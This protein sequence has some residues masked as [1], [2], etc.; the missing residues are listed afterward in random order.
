Y[1]NVSIFDVQ[2]AEELHQILMGLPL[3]P[4]MAIKVEALCRHPSSIRDDDR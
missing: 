4:F 3:Y 2:D 1:A